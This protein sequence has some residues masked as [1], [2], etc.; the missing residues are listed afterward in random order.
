MACTDE[1]GNACDYRVRLHLYTIGS[2]AVSEFTML[3]NAQRVYG[4]NRICIEMAS[5]QSLHLSDSERLTLDAVDGECKW[6]AVSDEQELLH[7]LGGNAGVGPFD[8]RVYYVNRLVQ[9]DGSTLNGCAGHAPTRAAVAVAATGSQWTMA[10]ELGHVLL[11]SGYRPVHEG[12]TT[13]LMHSPTTSIT[14]DPPTLTAAQ[15]TAIRASAYC[16]R[17]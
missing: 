2:P 12:S 9:T 13:N 1:L 8:I 3:R 7:S 11:G 15:L 16:R 17:V 14:A 6:D 4:P 5:G 10:H